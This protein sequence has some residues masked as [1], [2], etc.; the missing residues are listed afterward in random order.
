MDNS[1]IALFAIVMNLLHGGILAVFGIRDLIRKGEEYDQKFNGL[2]ALIKAAALILISLF[3]YYQLTSGVS[4]EYILF[5]MIVA[6]LL[7]YYKVIWD[8]RTRI[9][10]GVFESR[11]DILVQLNNERWEQVEARK[12]EYTSKIGDKAQEYLQAKD[13]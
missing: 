11:A 9:F 8:F 12:L 1:E 13:R 6:P 3:L 7:S 10:R 5:A 4:P 2:T